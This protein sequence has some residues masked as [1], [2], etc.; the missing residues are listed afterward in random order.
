MAT[1]LNV[2]AL[3]LSRQGPMPASTLQ[4]LCYYAQ[5]WH[6]VWEGRPLFDE[7]FQAWASG[8]VCPQLYEAHR[9]TFTV[10]E[11]PG[12]DPDRLDPD[13]VE[14]IDVV[15][16]HYAD[17]SAYR[18]GAL[19]RSES[20][21]RTARGDLAP[22]SRGEA[23][24]PEALAAE[25][26]ESLLPDQDGQQNAGGN[27]EVLTKAQQ[28]ALDRFRSWCAV[29]DPERDDDDPPN[30]WDI[31]I[32]E[33]PHHDDSHGS[34]VDIV[35]VYCSPDIVARAW[36]DCYGHGHRCWGEVDWICDGSED[37]QCDECLDGDRDE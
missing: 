25:Y 3:I 4:K 29:H 36:I 19:V 26:Y 8:P 22:G 32:A 30:L 7:E 2:S 5:A 28:N 21:W 34:A 31:D 24:I 14:S 35:A 15:L 20:P 33:R 10:T 37:C 12:G 9:G 16:D 6:L 13:E 18:L 17:M 1:I 11:E 27:R 23:P